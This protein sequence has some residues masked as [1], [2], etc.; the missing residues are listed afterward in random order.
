MKYQIA[1]CNALIRLAIAKAQ[2]KPLSYLKWV[3]Q[4]KTTVFILTK[5]LEWLDAT[6]AAFIGCYHV[7]IESQHGHEPFG[8]MQVDLRLQPPSEHDVV[9][10]NQIHRV[11]LPAMREDFHFVWESSNLDGVLDAI[12]S[13]DVPLCMAPKRGSYD[14]SVYEVGSPL[15]FG[16]FSHTDPEILFSVFVDVS[17]PAYHCCVAQTPAPST[18]R[19]RM[20]I[21]LFT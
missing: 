21:E 11:Q 8:T 17:A 19:T 18:G 14:L 7:P 5:A 3:S 20:T 12:L 2:S 10:D 13:V 9:S 16:H 6:T 15:S 4:I 1:A